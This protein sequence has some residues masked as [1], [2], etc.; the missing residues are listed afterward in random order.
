MK[1]TPQ[2]CEVDKTLGIV[3][4]GDQKRLRVVAIQAV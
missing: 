1:L 2:K 3:V 4:A